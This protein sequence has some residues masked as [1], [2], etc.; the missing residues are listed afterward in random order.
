MDNEHLQRLIVE[1]V[2]SPVSSVKPTSY[3]KKVSR[4]RNRADENVYKITPVTRCLLVS[5]LKKLQS[6]PRT[7][8]CSNNANSVTG[9]KDIYTP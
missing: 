8:K 4:N 3:L 6:A 2:D 1:S 9:S 7:P 5:D